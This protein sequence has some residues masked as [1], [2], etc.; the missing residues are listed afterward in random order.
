MKS[1]IISENT[2]LATASFI[3]G[4]FSTIILTYTAG[5]YGMDDLGGLK[6]FFRFA[7]DQSPLQMEDPKGLGYTTA[8]ASNGANIFLS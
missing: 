6:I 7:C 3:A 4:S 2:I 1:D 5:K 8:T